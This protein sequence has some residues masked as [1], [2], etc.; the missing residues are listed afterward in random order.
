MG[1]FLEMKKIT[2]LFN[3]NMVLNGVDFFA[4]KGKV[5]ALIGENGAGKTTLMKILAGLLKP[6]SGEIF[7]DGKLVTFNNPKHAQ[8]LGISMIY[9][10]IRLFSDL[11]IVENIFVRRELTKNRRFLNFIDWEKE[12][13]ETQKYIDYFGLNVDPKRLI[14]T[15]SVGQQKFIEII[16]ALSQNANI[17]IMDEP[18]SALNDKEIELLFKA[19]EDIKKLGVAVVYISH[20]LEEIKKIA[21]FITVIRDGELIQSC[22]VSDADIDS[23]VKAMAGKEHEDRYPKLKLKLGKEQLRVEKLSFSGRLNEISFSVRKG[24]IIGITG[25]SGSGRRTLA[26]VL[27]GIEGPFEGQIVLNGKEFKSIDTHAAMMNGLCYVAGSV[28]DEGLISNMQINENITL[29]NLSRISKIGFIDRTLESESVRDLIERLEIAADET[30]IA[31]NLSGG[32]QKK[33][34]YAKW[35]FSNARVLIVDEPTAGIDISSKVDIYNIINE[36]LMSGASVIMISSD[37][38]EVLGMCDKVIIMFNGEIK[39]IF[40]SSEMTQEKILFY[41]SGGK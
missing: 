20:R 11:N 28:S 27:C 23:L 37:L 22:D 26:K 40:D 1:S 19:V 38:P 41:A 30:E 2:K 16:R 35:L 13:R 15:L 3:E 12:Y 9:Q 8:D 39:G 7:I 36:L 24:E 4:D 10:E 25:L 32:K 17:I 21:D 31:E 29:T 33:V 34:I 5:S 14:S 6:D 18:T